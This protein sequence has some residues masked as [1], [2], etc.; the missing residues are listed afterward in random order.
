LSNPYVAIA[1]NVANSI[2]ANVSNIDL[3]SALSLDST[4]NQIANLM[5]YYPAQDTQFFRNS[6]NVVSDYATVIQFDQIGFT[7]KELLN[8]YIGTPKLISRLNS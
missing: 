8:N 5:S 1:A 6:Q 3:T 7:E 2:S 4:A